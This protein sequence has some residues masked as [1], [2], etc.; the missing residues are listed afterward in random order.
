MILDF[1]G[2]PLVAWVK[3]RPFGDSPGFEDPVKL[4]AKIIVQPRCIMLLDHEPMAVRR[5][6]INFTAW[7]SGFL[8]VALGAVCREVS[9]HRFADPSFQT[10]GAGIM[11]APKT[12]QRPD[13]RIA[14]ASPRLR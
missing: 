8:E 12:I 3:R 6:D 2:E 5:L 11:P 13:T 4:K 1:N 9:G 14:P 10:S 7:F